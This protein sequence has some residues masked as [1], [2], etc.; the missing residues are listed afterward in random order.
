MRD[1]RV[2]EG[3]VAA[4]AAVDWDWA[5][6]RWPGTLVGWGF[7]WVDSADYHHRHCW[8]VARFENVELLEEVDLVAFVAAAAAVAGAA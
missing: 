1:C 8:G 2:Q 7:G 5:G 4:A 6:N 3:V